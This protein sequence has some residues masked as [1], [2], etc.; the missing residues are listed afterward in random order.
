[1]TTTT[2]TAPADAQPV[3]VIDLYDKMSCVT[4]YLHGLYGLVGALG[5]A[6]P[7]SGDQMAALLQPVSEWADEV[8]IGLLQVSERG[9]MGR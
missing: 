7:V 9:K 8:R 1:M 5:P 3:S 4:E 2:K 6:M